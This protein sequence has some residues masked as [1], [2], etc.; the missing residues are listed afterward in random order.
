MKSNSNNINSVFVILAVVLVVVSLLNFGVIF[1]KVSEMNKA[2]TG[3][4]TG[5]VNLTVNTNIGVDINP[6]WGINWSNGSVT[7]GQNNATLTTSSNTSSVVSGNWST[8]GVRG[9]LIYNTGNTNASLTINATKNNTDWFGVG[10]AGPS[11][12]QFNVSNNE[13]N[14]C[15]GGVVALTAWTNVN[16]TAIKYCAQFDS[17]DTRDSVWLDVKL[18]VPSDLSSPNTMLSDTL[19]ITVA[20]AG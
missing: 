15:S 11:L 9:I 19:T 6:A 16:H 7:P 3:F 10:T 17:V 13:A 12:Y 5:Y 14:S 4:V 8:T 1:F 18:Q 20:A 2:V